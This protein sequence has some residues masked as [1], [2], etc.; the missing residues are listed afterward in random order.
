MPSPYLIQ[1]RYDDAAR[2]RGS[3]DASISMRRLKDAP[4]LRHWR[5][6]R[7]HSDI[8]RVIGIGP[9]AAWRLRHYSPSRGA[10]R[11]EMGSEGRALE[12]GEFTAGVISKHAHF[13][14]L[15]LSATAFADNRRLGRAR[16]LKI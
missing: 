15:W 2:L 12:Q 6:T 9:S 5:M 8:L 11:G 14:A 7:S 4:M 13:T 10:R 1:A 16:I 3:D